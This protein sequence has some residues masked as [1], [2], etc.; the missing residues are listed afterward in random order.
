MLG[1]FTRLLAGLLIAGSLGCGGGV[2]VT[3]AGPFVDDLSIELNGAC[4]GEDRVGLFRLEVIVDGNIP[5]SFVTGSILD[6]PDPTLVRELLATEGTCQLLRRPNPLC[7]PACSANQTCTIGDTC[8]ARSRPID[9]GPIR[10]GGLAEN[11][12]MHAAPPGNEYFNSELA[13]PAVSGGEELRLRATSGAISLDSVGHEALSVPS[14]GWS[15]NQ[16]QPLGVAWN[17]PSTGANTRVV[18]SLSID[19]HGVTPVTMGCVFEDTGTAEVPASV[20]DQLFAAGVSG[21]ANARLER[22]TVDSQQTSDGCMEFQV[23]HPQRVDASVGG[24]TPCNA[25]GE[26]PLGQT[27][28]LGSNTCIDE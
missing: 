10:V 28:D 18:L 26:C 23:V 11:I 24:H 9:S 17:V 20:V 22:Q 21:F 5:R 4:T 3:D 8:V 16:G 7:D 1:S 19:Q 13:H 2:A 15:I 14:G 6:Q 12:E 25:P 27:C